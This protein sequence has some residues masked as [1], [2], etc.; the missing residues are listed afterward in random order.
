MSSSSANVFIT[1]VWQITPLFLQ[2][3]QLWTKQ[4]ILKIVE[5]SSK[6]ILNYQGIHLGREEV[7]AVRGLQ[8]LRSLRSLWSQNR[9]GIHILAICCSNLKIN[10]FRNSFLRNKKSAPD[11]TLIW[12]SPSY[13]TQICN[14]W[15]LKIQIHQLIWEAWQGWGRDRLQRPLPFSLSV[16]G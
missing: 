14:S 3:P 4:P 7:F 16:S 5:S 13:S 1:E 8:I 10:H 9:V 12:M 11:L 15:S 2:R 6:T